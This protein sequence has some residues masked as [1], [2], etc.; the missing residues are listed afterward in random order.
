MVWPQNRE[1]SKPQPNQLWFARFSRS[2]FAKNGSEFLLS[3]QQGCFAGGTVLRRSP[4]TSLRTT[5][6]HALF[7][8]DHLAE[9]NHHSLDSHG[10]IDGHL[11]EVGLT[12]R[13]SKDVPGLISKN[14]E[15]SLV[16]AFGPIGISD[17]N[18][19]FW[20]AHPGGPAIL[21]Q[22]E[23]KLGLKPDRIKAT[24]HVLSEYGNISSACLLF[25]LDEMRKRSVEDGARTTGEGFDWG[26]LFG[27]GPGLTVE[28]AVLHGVV[29]AVSTH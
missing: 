29:I 23:D 26:V 10:A 7:G 9:S 21:D 22:V 18:S 17:W 16:E 6:A 20:I 27:F 4:K 14:I 5:K 2:D 1:P 12:F 24:G 25:I 28:T 19:M 8:D 3:Y 15:R 13:L 11:R